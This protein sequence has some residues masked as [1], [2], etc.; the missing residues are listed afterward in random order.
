MVHVIASLSSGEDA[1]NANRNKDIEKEVMRILR[2]RIKASEKKL[3]ELKHEWRED[4]L[5]FSVIEMTV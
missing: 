4:S 3:K 2:I 5:E 1:K